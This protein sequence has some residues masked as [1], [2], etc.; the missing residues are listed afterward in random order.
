VAKNAS[1]NLPKLLIGHNIEYQ[2]VYKTQPKASHHAEQG[3]D[4]TFR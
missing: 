2:T 4:E 1:G 3:G